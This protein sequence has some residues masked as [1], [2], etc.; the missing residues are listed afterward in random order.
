MYELPP[1]NGLRAFEAAARNLSF[2]K[3]ADELHVTPAAVSYQIR[4][5]ETKLGVKLFRRL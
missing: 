5:L 1:L 4:A 2:A 3:A